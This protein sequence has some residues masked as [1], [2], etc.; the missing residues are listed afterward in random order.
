MT[1]LDRADIQGNI[2]RAYGRMSFPFARYFFLHFRTQAAGRALLAALRPK[3]TTGAN[4]IDVGK[5][6][7]TLNLA[8]SCAGLARLGLPDLVLSQM[9]PAF[10]EGMRARASVLGDRPLRATEDEGQDWDAGWDPLW[11][12]HASGGEATVHMWLSM[13]AQLIALG[14]DTPVPDLDVQTDWLRDLC[15]NTLGDDVVLLR[16]HG[17]DAALDHLPASSVFTEIDG[18]RYPTP[19]EHFGLTDGIGD[20]VFAGQHGELDDPEGRDRTLTRVQGRGKWMGKLAGPAMG[21]TAEW[22]HKHANG[23]QPLEPGEFLLGLPDE[24]QELPPTARPP[25]FVRNGS[26]M[27][28]RKLH[29]NVASW[30]EVMDAEAETYAKVFEVPVAE[31]RETLVAK[32]IGRWSDGIPLATAPTHAAW[33]EVRA[34]HGFDGPDPATALANQRTYLASPEAS[35]FLY[36]DD[37]KGTRT[38]WGSH[39]RRVNPRDSLDPEFET[40]GEAHVPSTRLNKRRRILRRG[41]PYGPGDWAEKTDAT[42]Q[43][44]AM[45]VIG[46]NPFRQF[47]FVQSQWL[48][49]GLDFGEG[50]NPCPLTGPH[51]VHRRFAI[52]REEAAGGRPFLVSRLKTF[53]ETRGGEYFFLPSVR[54]VE[55]LASGSVDPT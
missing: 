40:G 15:A 12:A 4:W 46:A 26:Y 16:G 1:R 19:R 32:I 34:K 51:D 20:P 48:A 11:R 5:P 30:H 6:K 21:K 45:M 27:V 10:R 39:L 29:Q 37:P 47:E 24:A 49:T 52:P 31:A 42:D 2:L 44:I 28:F 55:M 9:A 8:L 25:E 43:G 41:L 53:V 14:E 50:S 54:A 18:R 36:D 35:T 3:L 23:W 13:N 17:G 22:W 33:L 38:P 7:V